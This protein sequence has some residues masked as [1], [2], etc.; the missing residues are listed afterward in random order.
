MENASDFDKQCKALSDA[1]DIFLRQNFSASPK[2][3]KVLMD[4]NLV[5]IRVDDFFCP[6]EVQMGKK[7]R[8]TVL[9]HE[10]YSKLFNETKAALLERVEQITRKKVKS[11]QLNINFESEL[12]VMDFHLASKPDGENMNDGLPVASQEN[13]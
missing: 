10:M 13:K 7:K 8:D 4:N 11:S 3:I 5:V 12:C 6:A 2:S 9:I 1:A